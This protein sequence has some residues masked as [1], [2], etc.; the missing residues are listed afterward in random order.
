MKKIK[1]NV[2]TGLVFGF[3]APLIVFIIY[4]KIKQPD[5]AFTD[6]VREFIRLKI[7]T[8]VLSF[9]AFVNLAV[10]FLFIW[11]NKEKSAR[12]VLTATLIYAFVIIILKVAG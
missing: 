10:F 6:V 4:T 7:F 11:T 9:A 8:V 3:I 1:D 12:G 2:F 5:D